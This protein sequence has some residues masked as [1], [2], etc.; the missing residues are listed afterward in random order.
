MFRISP[1]DCDIH[2]YL[3]NENKVTQDMAA[4]DGHGNAFL[5]KIDL[6]KLKLGFESWMLR[7]LGC[8][9][10]LHVR[11]LEG[12]LSWVEEEWEESL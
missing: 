10:L 4:K 9:C 8:S 5:C 2:L 3:D 6:E 11:N 7:I 1:K 12:S